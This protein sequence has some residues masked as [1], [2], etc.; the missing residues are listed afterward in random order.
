MPKR[1]FN[2]T[3][4]LA[5]ALS[6]L[7]LVPAACLLLLG[8]PAPRQEP[9]PSQRG[10]DLADIQAKNAGCI[11]CHTQTDSATMHPTETVHVGC[12]DCHGGSWSVAI[13][14]GTAPNSA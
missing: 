12:V 13:T 4:Q 9:R 2:S 6:V 3:P 14:P 7:V 1:L 11:S 5:T 8:N 10:N